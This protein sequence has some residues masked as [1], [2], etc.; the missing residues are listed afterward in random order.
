MISKVNHKTVSHCRQRSVS[1]IK[2]RVRCEVITRLKPFSFEYAPKNFGNVKMRRIR[3]QE[4]EVKSSLFPDGSQCLKLL[5]S[6]NRSIVKHEE[7]LPLNAERKVVQVS[8]HLV[9]ID[10]FFCGKPASTTVAVNHGE[11]IESGTTL[12]RYEN[13]FFG[14]FPSVGHICLFTEMGFISVKKINRAVMPQLF[15]LLQLPTLKLV[16]L[17]RGFPLWTFSYTSKSCANALKKRRSVSSQAVFPVAACHCALAAKMLERLRSIACR[18]ISSS[19][20]P[21]IGLRPRPGRVLSPSI[22]SA[23]NRFTQLLTDTWCIS[24]C[25]PILGELRPCAFNNTALHRILKACDVPLRNPF[26]SAAC[27]TEVNSNFL[28]LPMRREMS[29][30]GITNFRAKHYNLNYFCE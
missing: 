18:M 21:I 1:G 23:W 17:R 2:E 25:S 19:S 13:I 15:K 7:G 8:N 26:S 20:V 10:T 6:M 14:K 24:S 12:G 4:K 9:G 30:M 11:A 29:F 16:E 28:I 27:C 3:W 22:P 5:S